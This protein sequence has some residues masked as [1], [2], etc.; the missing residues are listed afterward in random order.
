MGEVKRRWWRRKGVI[1]ALVVL[2]CAAT[3]R[4]ENRHYRDAAGNTTGFRW[5]ILLPWQRLPAV[6]AKDGGSV[7]SQSSLV[8]GLVTLKHEETREVRRIGEG[9]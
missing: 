7:A 4:Y 1:T 2:A 6:E 9:E 5:A 3:L 8:F